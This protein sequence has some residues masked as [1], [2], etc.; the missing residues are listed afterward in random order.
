M[1]RATSSLPV[2]G[3]PSMSAVLLERATRRTSSR[4]PCIPGLLVT[5]S[6]LV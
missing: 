2:P 4:T 3:S 5:M 1:A 6:S